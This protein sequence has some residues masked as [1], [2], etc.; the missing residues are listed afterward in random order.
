[1]AKLT[2]LD[3]QWRELMFLCEQES[4]FRDGQDHPK[5]LKFLAA[6]VDEL[7]RQ[8]GFS[9]RLIRTRVFRAVRDDARIVRV[10]TDSE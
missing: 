7:A 8:I 6:R 4:R 5:L 2:T 1:M 9:D 3:V 10:L